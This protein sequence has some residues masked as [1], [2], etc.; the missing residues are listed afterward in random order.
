MSLSLQTRPRAS[1]SKE[2]CPEI[3][4]DLS[5]E[6]IEELMELRMPVQYK[7]GDLIFQEGEFASGVYIICRGMVR[8]EKHYRGKKL[9]L[10][11][12]QAG[13]LLGIEALAGEGPATRP[14]YAQAIEDTQVAFI[15]KG[16]FLAFC[17]EHPGIIAGLYQGALEKIMLLQRK[18]VQSALASADERL[19]GILLELGQSCGTETEAG[20]FINVHFARSE[21]A[22]LVGVSLETLVRSLSRLNHKGLIK[23]HGHKRITIH[24]P[25]RLEEMAAGELTFASSPIT[26]RSPSAIPIG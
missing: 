19:A 24:D 3:F 18:L 12:L 16:A 21:L 5:Q 1:R 26:R 13:D 9:T 6:E 20:V 17:R 8:V 14:G 25:A 22:E 11:F 10:E 23:L 4:S 7:R 15:E 2:G